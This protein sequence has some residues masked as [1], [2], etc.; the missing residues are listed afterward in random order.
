ML[1]ARIN[2][3]LPFIFLCVQAWSL[4]TAH[5]SLC[6]SYCRP[7]DT[8]T[9]S[10]WKLT[11]DETSF[12]ELS[13]CNRRE[14]TYST[15]EYLF[16]AIVRKII[17]KHIMSVISQHNHLNNCWQ[18]TLETNRSQLFMLHFHI[19]LCSIF[20]FKLLQCCGYGL[21]WFRHK[22]KH[23]VRVSDMYWLK[24]P[25]SI[26]RNTTRQCPHISSKISSDFRL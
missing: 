7:A 11:A 5:M 3:I 13:Q 8:V 15:L 26:A 9:S 14:T 12:H 25:G 24:I 22:K 23:L 6:C 4:S 2:C 19:S 21:V 1:L 17:Q 16:T 10:I 18:Y 20:Y